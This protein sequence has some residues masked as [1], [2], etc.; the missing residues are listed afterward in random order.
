MNEAIARAAPL[1]RKH[2]GRRA[3][4]YQDTVG[5]L[6]IGIGR[7]LEKGLSDD[8]IEY[9]FANDLNEAYAIASS[10][11]YWALLSRRRQD[12]LL[13]MAFQLGPSRLAGFKKM[14]AALE[15]HDYSKA[16]DEC[17]DSRY[18]QQVPR[19]ANTIADMI[20]NG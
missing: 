11:R 7:N 20:R 2:E 16:A 14:H 9:L 5:V 18:A 19:R 1:I 15:Q 3:L 4:P 10:Y 6:S 8:E 13:N 12:A 17:L